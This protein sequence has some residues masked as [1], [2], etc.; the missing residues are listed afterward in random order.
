MA[1]QCTHWEAIAF[2]SLWH[3]LLP[4]PPFFSILLSLS[5][6]L[7]VFLSHP[8]QETEFRK[9]PNP[10]TITP[11]APSVI[12]FSA[13]ILFV[14]SFVC[15]LIFLRL[16]WEWFPSSSF[17]LYL[18]DRPLRTPVLSLSFLCC[19]LSLYRSVFFHVCLISLICGTIT[20]TRWKEHLKAL[21]K[22]QY[23]YNKLLH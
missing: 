14:L 6:K 22:Y 17:S 2:I 8:L 4:L 3:P 21:R 1:F 23:F 18:S 5:V 20:H 19:S 13:F 11:A 16:L 12:S 9:R 7:S 15:F 10:V